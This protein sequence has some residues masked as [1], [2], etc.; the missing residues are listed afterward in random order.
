LRGLTGNLPTPKTRK[1]LPQRATTLLLMCSGGEMLLEKRPASGIW[2]GLWSLPEVG[3]VSEIGAAA[4]RYGVRVLSRQA[5]PGIAHGFTHFKLDIA[6]L[7]LEV[8]KAK[9]VGVRTSGAAAVANIQWCTK[10]A[11]LAAGIPTP[12]RKILLSV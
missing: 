4:K 6:P 2:G 12:V 7:K 8:K 5:L 3:G 11:A 1:A 10:A 9:R